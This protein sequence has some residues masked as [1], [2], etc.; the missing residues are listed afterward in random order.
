MSRLPALERLVTTLKKLPG[1]GEK[2]ATR[3]AFFV[4]AAPDA[5]A[6]E[7]AAAI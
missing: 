4:L 1:I 5:F 2:S 6:E 3:L 7:L